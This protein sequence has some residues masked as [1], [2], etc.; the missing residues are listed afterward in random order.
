M[1]TLICYWNG[2]IT[3]AQEGVS[4]KDTLLVATVTI[5]RVTFDDF[6]DKLYQVT[7][8]VKQGTCLAVTCKHKG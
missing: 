8:Y 2:K 6:M 3:D 1:L 7:S 5:S 4:Y